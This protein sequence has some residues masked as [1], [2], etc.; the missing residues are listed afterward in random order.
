VEA[1]PFNSIKYKWSEG[2]GHGKPT[3]GRQVNVLPFSSL[4]FAKIIKAL[5]YPKKFLTVYVDY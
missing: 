2:A 1:V 3:T 5:L 4:H